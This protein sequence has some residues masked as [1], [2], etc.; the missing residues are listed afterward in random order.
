MYHDWLFWEFIRR[1]YLKRHLILCHKLDGVTTRRAALVAPRG[2]DC[3]SGYY[4]EVSNDDSVLDI[5]RDLIDANQSEA[6]AA[7]NSFD[8]TVWDN[9][10][11]SD[12]SVADAMGKDDIDIL[13]GDVYGDIS[14]DVSSGASGSAVAG[15]SGGGVSNDVIFKDALGVIIGDV[16]MGSI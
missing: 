12:V 6:D 10:Q 8:T 4:K 5:L 7:L 15:V 14:G 3:P 11:S 13:D 1:S 9:V 16:A 2:D